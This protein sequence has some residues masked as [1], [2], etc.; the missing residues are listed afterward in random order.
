MAMV[1][2]NDA[3]FQWLLSQ[4]S[5]EGPD[6]SYF[7]LMKDLHDTEFKAV[8][9]LDENRI[10]DVFEL[11]RG[12]ENETDN[13]IERTGRVS[14]LEVLIRLAE[15]A[16]FIADEEDDRNKWF[17]IFLHNLGLDSFTDENYDSEEVRKIVW[18]FVNRRYTKTGKGGIFP[19]K[20]RTKTDQRLLELWY[21]LAE[22]LHENGC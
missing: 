20:R 5:F 8:V 7:L 3:Y 11:R 16:T 4:V 2:P 1:T 22:Y 19:L 18:V 13:D 6:Y 17:W 21:Q 14:V 12:Y 10:N 9:E 15:R